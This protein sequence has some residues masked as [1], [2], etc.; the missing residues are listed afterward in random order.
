VSKILGLNNNTVKVANTA[1]AYSKQREALVQFGIHDWEQAIKK[2]IAIDN[3][4]K[5]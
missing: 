4:K 2:A 1:N 5:V 3:G